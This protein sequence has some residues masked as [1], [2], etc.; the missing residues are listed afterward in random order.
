MTAGKVSEYTTPVERRPTLKAKEDLPI[1]LVQPTA[2][3]QLTAEAIVRELYQTTQLTRNIAALPA[4]GLKFVG[5][6]PKE[7]Y[8]QITLVAND[9]QQFKSFTALVADD[10]AQELN[11]H[12]MVGVTMVGCVG[13][14]VSSWL[15]T[16]IKTL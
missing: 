16:K 9:D 14:K 3:Q 7:R 12:M 11:R 8:Q 2:G 10:L 13:G 1:V 6:S 5:L 4:H 15:I